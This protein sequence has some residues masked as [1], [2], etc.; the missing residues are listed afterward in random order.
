MSIEQTKPRKIPKSKM[1]YLHS[2]LKKNFEG[3]KYTVLEEK[4]NHGDKG[5]TFKYYSRKEGKIVKYTGK[6]VGP[7]EYEVMVTKGTS[8]DEEKSAKDHKKGL[9]KKSLLEYIKKIDGLEF[10]SKYLKSLK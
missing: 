6:Q 9:N 8:K 1:I 7:D 3:G 10:V 4:I 5:L 2:S